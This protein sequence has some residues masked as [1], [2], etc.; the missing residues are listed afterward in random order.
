MCQL[1][2]VSSPASLPRPPNLETHLSPNQFPL[3]V[4]LLVL[5]V[6]FLQLQK[7]EQTLQLLHLCV[8]I[9]F[10][11]HFQFLQLVFDDNVL[12]SSQDTGGVGRV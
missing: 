2:R 5:D 11:E 10:G 9:L 1:P 7:L 4:L 12:L 3:Q 8:E 6:L